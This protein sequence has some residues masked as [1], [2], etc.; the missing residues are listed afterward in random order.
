MLRSFWLLLLLLLHCRYITM[1][2]VLALAE[3]PV[4]PQLL[5]GKLVPENG[6]WMVRGGLAAAAAI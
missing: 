2:G 5:D 3:V 1:R 6:R 4:L